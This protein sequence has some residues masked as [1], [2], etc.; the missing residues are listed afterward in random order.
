MYRLPA[1]QGHL[2]TSLHKLAEAL[3]IN[4]SSLHHC[5]D[6]Q[7]EL[8]YHLRD[9]YICKAP[10]AELQSLCSGDGAPWSGTMAS[11]SPGWVATVINSTLHTREAVRALHFRVNADYRIKEARDPSAGARPVAVASAPTKPGQQPPAHDQAVSIAGEDCKRSMEW[12]VHRIIK[13]D[14]RNSHRA[15]AGGS[16]TSF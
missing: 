4:Q 10:A 7:Q 1:A 6:A 11:C 16:E 9:Y 14:S 2:V 5:Y 13:A 8:L 12:T 15:G 3:G